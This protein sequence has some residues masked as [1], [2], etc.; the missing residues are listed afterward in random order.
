MSQLELLHE[1]PTSP[2][3][4]SGHTAIY[5]MH[6]YFARRPHN[7]FRALIEQHVQPGGVVLDCFAGGGVTL[8]EGLTVGRRVISVDV[9]PIASLIQHAQVAEADPDRVIALSHQVEA[10]VP[11]EHRAW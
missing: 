3:T 2:T 10:A 7:V 8:V 4:S 1:A 9:N 11:P 5:K 6:K